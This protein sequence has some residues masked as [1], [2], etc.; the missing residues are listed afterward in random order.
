MSFNTENPVCNGKVCPKKK[1]CNRYIGF[2]IAQGLNVERYWTLNPTLKERC[3]EIPCK[4]FVP[5]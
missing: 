3:Q 5:A 4:H 1:E 2:E